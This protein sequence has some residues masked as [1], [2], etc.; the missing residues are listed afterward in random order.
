MKREISAIQI[1]ERFRRE[2]GGLESLAESIKAQG[3]LQPIGITEEG[4]LVFGGRRLKACRD[5][6]G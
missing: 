5:V 4:V 2:L 3:L 6:L 1:G